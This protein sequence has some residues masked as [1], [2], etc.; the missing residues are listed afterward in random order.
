MNRKAEYLKAGPLNFPR[1]SGDE[2]MGAE[3]G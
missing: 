2:P 3:N 1:A